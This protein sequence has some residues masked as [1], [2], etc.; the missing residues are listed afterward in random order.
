MSKNT[1]ATNDFLETQ[2]FFASSIYSISKPE[3]LDT[4]LQVFQEQI[5]IV[6][7]KTKSDEL[8][9]SYMTHSFVDDRLKDFNY[10]VLNTA[11]QVL[12]E[13]GLKMDNK[14]TY[15]H[16]LWGQEHYKYSSMEQHIHGENTQIVGFY[17]LECPE[18]CPNLLIHDPRPG[19]CQ[20][21]LDQQ[22]EKNV[23]L[24]SNLI[25]FKPVPGSLW[26]TNSWLPHSFTKNGADEPFKFI[27]FNISVVI[28][29]Q[30][31]PV[32]NDV[33]VEII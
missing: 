20:I 29:E 8:Y 5:D 14:S 28:N 19:K 12:N 27:H 18:K 6:K 33:N 16:S 32:I 23:T 25:N 13:Q 26:F 30:N 17:F 3:F 15:F 22:D 21:N 2:S 24:S 9:D 7:N 1:D 4:A 31:S 11:W 10:Y